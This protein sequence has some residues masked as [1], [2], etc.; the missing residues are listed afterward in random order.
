MADEQALYALYFRMHAATEGHE[1]CD[2]LHLGA[3]DSHS[4]DN[5][6]TEEKLARP[7]M[8]ALM[9]RTFSYGKLGGSGFDPIVGCGVH[10]W[11]ARAAAVGRG[12]LGPRGI[13]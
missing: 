4:A 6:L 2:V 3:R 12:L 8:H 1:T 5:Q 11:R 7:K 10:C 13:L 9:G